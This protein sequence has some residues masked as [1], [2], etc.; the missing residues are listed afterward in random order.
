MATQAHRIAMLAQHSLVQSQT[1][2]CY[3]L[4]PCCFLEI[5]ISWQ[6]VA[7]PTLR[8]K[9]HLDIW[10]A[11]AAE[12]GG[13]A[14]KEAEAHRSQTQEVRLSASPYKCYL[15]AIVWLT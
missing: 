2:L 12:A 11:A 1:W 8:N 15:E 5:A 4:L 14:G 9:T 3:A 10:G 7:L 13:A 6:S